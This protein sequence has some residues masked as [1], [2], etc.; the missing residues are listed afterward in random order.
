MSI[1]ISDTPTLAVVSGQAAALPVVR[2][3]S[4]DFTWVIIMQLERDAAHRITLELIRIIDSRFRDEELLDIYREAMPV[5][6]EGICDYAERCD[7][8]AA[9]LGKTHG[10]GPTSQDDQTQLDVPSVE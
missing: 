2:R 10:N 8:R 7:R 5:V 1:P 4:I 6:I 3:S 9:R